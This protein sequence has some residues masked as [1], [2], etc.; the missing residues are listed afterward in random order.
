SN[1]QKCWTREIIGMNR[2]ATVIVCLIVLALGPGISRVFAEIT[3]AADGRS[4]YAIVVSGEATETERTA[5]AELKRYLEAV[6]GARFPIVSP[7]QVGHGPAIYVGVLATL[8]HPGLDT[9]AQQLGRGA[10]RI[11]LAG[12]DLLIGGSDPRATLHAV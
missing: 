11:L 6:T 8:Q 10:I 12:D 9:Q 2:V 4:E 7:D 1:R 5:A 3:L